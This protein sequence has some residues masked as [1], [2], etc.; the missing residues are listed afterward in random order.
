MGQ[1]GGVLYGEI[2]RMPTSS[3]F[4]SPPGGAFHV[5]TAKSRR[6]ACWAFCFSFSLF[7]KI[8]SNAHATAITPPIPLTME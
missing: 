7:Q 5:Y 3:L 8:R 6:R 4:T 1:K 2:V